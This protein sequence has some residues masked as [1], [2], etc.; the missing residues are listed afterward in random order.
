MEMPDSLVFHSWW[1]EELATPLELQT[2][3]QG[4]GVRRQVK[5]HY[6]SKLGSF[7]LFAENVRVALTLTIEHA[8]GTPVSPYELFVGAKLDVLGRSMTLRAASAQTISWIDAEAK[9][10]LRRRESLCDQVI[11]FKDLHKALESVG[12]AQLYLNRDLS[13]TKQ[14]SLPNGGKANLHQLHT[15]V[16]ALEELLV[17]YRS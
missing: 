17:R 11:K 15:E 14:A 8:D 1:N 16:S 7:Q 6:L 4:M 3:G 5:L 12:I 9:R 2:S 10:L 13:S